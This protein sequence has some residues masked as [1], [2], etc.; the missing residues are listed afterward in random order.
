[1][2]SAL[3]VLV[4]SPD[5]VGIAVVVLRS[6]PL[7]MAVAEVTVSDVEVVVASPLLGRV[8]VELVALVELLE[9]VVL[10]MIDEDSPVVV[11]MVVES[12]VAALVVVSYVE[13]GLRSV[14][15]PIVVEAVDSV[16]FCAGRVHTISV[17]A[18][19]AALFLAMTL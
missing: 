15:D 18:A 6:D 11:V 9:L 8:L 1:M 19:E 16:A 14:V 3:L 17:T 4:R 10:V 7:V 5:V 2:V 12:R 13:D